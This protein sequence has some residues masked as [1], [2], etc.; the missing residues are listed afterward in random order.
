MSRAYRTAGSDACCVDEGLTVVSLQ[1][2]K[3]GSRS[4][5]LSCRTFCFDRDNSKMKTELKLLIE[6]QLSELIELTKKAD[7]FMQS[8]RLPIEIV[9][10][11]HLILEEVLTSIIKYGYRD[12]LKHDIRIEMTLKEHELLLEFED[13]GEEFDPLY[14]PAPETRESI[15]E[16]TI[17]GLGIHLVKQMVDGIEYQRHNGRNILRARVGLGFEA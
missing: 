6:N 1:D 14:A 13:D 5:V 8:H 4:S 9:Y 17:G 10:K 12:A 3:R 16:S 11:V 2:S 7:R 15:S